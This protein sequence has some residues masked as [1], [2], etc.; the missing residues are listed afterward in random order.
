MVLNFESQVE[1]GVKIM[2][3][4]VGAW[5]IDQNFSKLDGSAVHALYRAP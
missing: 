2:A 5:L 3:E 4:E 1:G